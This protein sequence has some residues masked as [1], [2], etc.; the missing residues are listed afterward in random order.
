MDPEKGKMG[1]LE[2]MTTEEEGWAMAKGLSNRYFKGR[3]VKCSALTGEGIEGVLDEVS[4]IPHI[5]RGKI[6]RGKGVVLITSALAGDRCGQCS[7]YIP[8]QKARLAVPVPL[9][10]RTVRSSSIV[11]SIVSCSVTKSSVAFFLSL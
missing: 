9:L 4:D 6:W 5:A 1:D 10:Y 3:Y 8:L 11:R 2:M 7:S